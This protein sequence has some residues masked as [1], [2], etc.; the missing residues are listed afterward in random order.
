[1]ASEEKLTALSTLKKRRD[2]FHARGAHCWRK[3]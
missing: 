2:Y 1:M 3:R